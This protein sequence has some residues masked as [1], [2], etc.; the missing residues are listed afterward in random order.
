MVDHQVG[1]ARVDDLVEGYDLGGRNT[2]L[3][4]NGEAVI[5]FLDSVVLA[6]TGGGTLSS[7]L[8]G[9]RGGLFGAGASL[10]GTVGN[11]ETRVTFSC[12]V[13]PSPK[14]STFILTFWW[15]PSW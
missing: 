1:T 2:I 9:S 5:A 7:G 3:V 10:L 15:W 6:A 11:R 14:R 12:L 4:A 8:L 13:I